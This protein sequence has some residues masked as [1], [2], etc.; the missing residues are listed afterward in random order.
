MRSEGEGPN[1]MGYKRKVKSGHDK[2]GEM[3][4]RSEKT[5]KV[6]GVGNLQRDIQ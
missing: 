3:R 4:H 1:G 2:G 6:E 5:C